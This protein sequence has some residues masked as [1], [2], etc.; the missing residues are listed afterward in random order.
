MFQ[1]LYFFTNKAPRV[2]MAKTV[3]IYR[4]KH[5][6]KTHW[7]IRYD[8]NKEYLMPYAAG[9]ILCFRDEII[10]RIYPL[11]DVGDFKPNYFPFIEFSDS[12]FT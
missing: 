7:C 11:A 2:C 9:D 10:A 4:R 1:L 3:R 12:D 8:L 5:S 6:D